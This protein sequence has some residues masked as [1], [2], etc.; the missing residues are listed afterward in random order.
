MIARESLKAAER[1]TCGATHRNRMGGV[2]T[3]GERALDREAL[4]IKPSPRRSGARAGTADESYLGRSRFAS[5]RKTSRAAGDGARSQQR[6][7]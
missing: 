2:V 1:K 5:E 6:P 3:Q 4:A 7:Q